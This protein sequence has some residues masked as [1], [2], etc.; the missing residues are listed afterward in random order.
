MPGGRAYNRK[1]F[2]CLQVDGPV[3]WPLINGKVGINKGQ[4]TVFVYIR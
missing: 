4:F 2:F 1:Y 3:P